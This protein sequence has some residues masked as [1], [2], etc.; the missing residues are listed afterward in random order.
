MNG[1]A[2]R[3]DMAVEA[4]AV[5]RGEADVEIAGVRE[6]VREEKNVS[7]EDYQ[8]VRE[9]FEKIGKVA[10]IEEKSGIGFARTLARPL[11][12]G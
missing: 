3:L 10:E 11:L 5:L 6:S 8:L 9:L 4:A 7:D 2:A 12:R 1:I